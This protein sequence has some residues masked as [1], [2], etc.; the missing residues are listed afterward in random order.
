MWGTVGLRGAAEL[1]RARR[2][3][4][5]PVFLGTY[6][7]RLDDKGRLALPARFRA[8]LSEGVVITKGQDRCLYAYPL[9][10]F[11]RR[12]EQLGT[13]AP[14]DRRARDF[15]RILFASASHEVPDGQGRIVV[16]APLRTYA[17][18]NKDCVVTGAYDRVD[19]WDA[20][21]WQRYL[22]DREDSFAD[23][24][25]EVLPGLF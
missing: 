20:G 10:T 3:G 8:D 17:G 24:A 14:T 18:L 1:D 22:A 5:V 25:E 19:I 21:T 11:A 2:V 9:A 16:P 6:T 7:P 4:A 12:T 15:A 23:Q 13:A